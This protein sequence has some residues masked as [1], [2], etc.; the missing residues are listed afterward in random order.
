MEYIFKKNIDAPPNQVTAYLFVNP[1]VYS[2]KKHQCEA[3]LAKKQL[4]INSD[5]HT[6]EKVL[7]LLMCAGQEKQAEIAR[8]L[9]PLDISLTQLNLLHTLDNQKAAELTVNQIKDMMVEDSPNVSRALSKLEAKGLIRKRRS[10]KDQRTV[11]VCITEQ[12]RDMHLKGDKSIM[13]VSLPLR[14]EEFTLLYSL[15]AKL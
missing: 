12:G 8:L 6:S 15:L 3:L 9:K 5:L 1:R 7:G 14:E 10:E 2:V 11:Y 13:N 4:I